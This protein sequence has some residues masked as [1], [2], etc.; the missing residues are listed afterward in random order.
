MGYVILLWHSLSLPYKYLIVMKMFLLCP[1]LLVNNLRG[2]SFFCCI[3]HTYFEIQMYTMLRSIEAKVERN[4]PY[5]SSTRS[6]NNTQTKQKKTTHG[7]GRNVGL[8]ILSRKRVCAVDRY[9]L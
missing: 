3:F 2:H 6:E 7:D 8:L 9:N 5:L 4:V 1:M